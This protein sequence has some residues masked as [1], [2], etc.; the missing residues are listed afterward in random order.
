MVMNEESYWLGFSA[1]SGIGPLRFQ[2]LL[3][4]FGT[5]K[6]AWEADEPLLQVVLGNAITAKF[7]SFKKT[8]SLEN[9][10]Q[11]LS[12]KKIS[13]LLSK[14]TNYP[15]L[16]K[17]SPTAPYVLYCK[18][19]VS[20]VSSLGFVDS[21]QA[22]L[23]E[24]STRRARMT[25]VNSIAVVGTRKV[26][27]YGKE[28]TELL[29]TDLVNQGF[30][31]VS[32]LALG[33]DGIAHETTMD[34]GGK[35]IAVL[36]CGVDCCNPSNNQ[37]IYDK[38]IGNF[39]AIVS[40]FAFERSIAK[41]MFPARNRIIAGLSLGVLV[42]EG[43][44]DS[45]AL[46]TAQRAFELQRPVFAVPGPITSGLSKGP[47][48]LIQKGAHVVQRVENILEVFNMDTLS[49]TKGTLSAHSDIPEEQEIIDVLIRGSLYP[50]ELMR[51]IGKSSMDIGSILSMMEI[52]GLV[53][54]KGGKL[55]L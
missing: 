25:N 51:K 55:S 28:V 31:I 3:A 46:I 54:N 16:L 14:N 38:I 45:G 2:K 9:Y 26:S 48:S 37:P 36:G 30:C 32:G 50:D 4:A 34:A 42:T 21:G 49:T 53:K 20:L 24:A 23:A 7:I 13:F 47:L 19:D 10:L 15:Q 29:T 43:S 12:D 27:A 40:E 22:H 44:E 8:F 35:T 5:A 41:G 6:N 39:G 17:D 1:F 33:V 18:G 11:K 52:K